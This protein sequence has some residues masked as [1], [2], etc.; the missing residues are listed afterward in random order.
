M[1]PNVATPELFAKALFTDTS[2]WTVIDRGPMEAL[3]PITSVLENMLDTFDPASPGK[4][5]LEVSENMLHVF[6]AY[7]GGRRTLT[8]VWTRA[9]SMIAAIAAAGFASFPSSCLDYY[10]GHLDTAVSFGTLLLAACDFGLNQET[11]RPPRTASFGAERH[12]SADGGVAAASFCVEASREESR[13]EM[14]PPT[15]LDVLRAC[16]CCREFYPQVAR[17]IFLYSSCLT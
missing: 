10:A 6:P 17:G 9:G 5:K 1:G 11:L 2:S 13:G 14:L 12:E 7:A 4:T 15:L 3:L 16:C 8:G